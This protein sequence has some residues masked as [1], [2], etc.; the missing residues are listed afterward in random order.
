MDHGTLGL[1]AVLALAFLVE[2]AAGFGS[3]LVVVSVAAI[4]VPLTTL[5]PT[6]QPLSVG[7]SLV[8][9][10][11]ERAHI[12][13]AFLRRVVLPCM[14]PGVVVGMVLFR[15][16]KPHALL[17]VVGLA[18]VALAAFELV[19]LHRETTLVTSSR[20]RNPLV[21]LALVVAGVIHGLFGTSGPLVV[22]AATHTLTDKARFRATL[23][24]LWLI[25][26]AALVIGFMIDGTLTSS[27]ALASARLLPTMLVG[28]ALGDRIHRR[29]PQRTFRIGV[30][31]LLIVAGATLAVRSSPAMAAAIGQGA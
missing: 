24:T 17:F 25:L 23:S 9:A 10:W 6:Y 30:C 7:L 2:A 20:S 3:T 13:G 5:L 21:V 26:S 22:W 19:R 1:A 12:D 15:V 28:Y 14:V 11:R 31:V 16:W 8:V 4:F 18:I 29:V 27:S